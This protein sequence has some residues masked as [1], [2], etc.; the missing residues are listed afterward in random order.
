MKGVSIEYYKTE[1]DDLV[2][3]PDQVHKLI[4]EFY[5]YLSC[6]SDQDAATTTSHLDNMLAE[7]VRRKIVSQK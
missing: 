1:E 7:L 5:S 6:D 3:V 2:V 4:S